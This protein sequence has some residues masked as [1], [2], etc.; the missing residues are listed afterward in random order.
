MDFWFCIFSHPC[1]QTQK[2]FIILFLKTGKPP[3]QTLEIKGKFGAVE[4]HTFVIFFL[5]FFYFFHCSH[6]R[7][8]YFLFYSLFAPPRH[9]L[10][11]L[12]TVR[13]TA[14]LTFYFIHCFIRVF[15]SIRVLLTGFGNP[16]ELNLRSMSLCLFTSVFPLLSLL[17]VFCWISLPFVVVDW[18]W[19]PWRIKPLTNES[20]F[21]YV[22]IPS[23]YHCY[24]CSVGYHCHLLLLTG[25]GNPGELNL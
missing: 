2:R 6:H 12:F 9:L 22:C 7:E 16:G 18:L 13:T 23:A 5:S 25:F 10:S 21:V 14:T 17:F 8:S 4:T 19:Q 20:L 11:I 24:L 1:T 3:T 15:I